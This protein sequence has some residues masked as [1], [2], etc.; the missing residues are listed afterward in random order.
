MDEICKRVR[1]GEIIHLSN[2]LQFRPIFDFLTSKFEKSFNVQR[3]LSQDFQ[4]LDGEIYCSGLIRVVD[5]LD[6][7]LQHYSIMAQCLAKTGISQDEAFL[8]IT[9]EKSLRTALFGKYKKNY[10]YLHHRDSWFDLSPDGV[11]IVIYLTDVPYEG[12]TIFYKKYFQSPLQ[13]NK[14]KKSPLDFTIDN[15]LGEITTYDCNAGD[16]LIFA[17][18]HLHSGPRI[19]INRLSIEFRLS[20]LWNHGRP[21]QKI[22]YQAVNDFL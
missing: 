15:G 4:S 16:V 8:R 3:T 1:N 2:P 10:G 5:E 6:E 11:N 22:Y 17:G 12:N 13:F 18:D 14:E 7:T 9:L 20:K 19:E 21:E